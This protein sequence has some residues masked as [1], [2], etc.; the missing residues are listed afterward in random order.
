[1]RAEIGK[2]KLKMPLYTLS[3]EVKRPVRERLAPRVSDILAT[4]AAKSEQRNA[5]GSVKEEM[6]KE[7]GEK[8]QSTEIRRRGGLCC[9]RASPVD[10]LE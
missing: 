6:V 3:D 5:R 9:E 10:D 1:M 8:F 2:A 7:L 4:R